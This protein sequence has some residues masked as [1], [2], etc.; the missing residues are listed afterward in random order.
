MN[1]FEYL[2]V[3]KGPEIEQKEGMCYRKLIFA[4]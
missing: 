2:D 1:V 3:L 4:K